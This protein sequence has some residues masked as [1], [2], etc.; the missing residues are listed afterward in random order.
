[1]TAQDEE[2]ELKKELEGV[3]KKIKEAQAA[4]ADTSFAEVCKDLKREA[5]F[6]MKQ[7]RVLKGHI[8]KVT[9][10]H[11]CGD[12]KKAV[13]GSLDGKLIVWD[14]FSGNK[15]RVIP[16]RSSWVMS[17]AYA[18]NGNYVAVGGMDNMCT[19]YD[20]H[21]PNAKVRRE[22]TGL[23]GYLSSVRFLSDANVI[24]G[25]GDTKVVLW[26][27]DR[28]AKLTTY[29]GHEGDVTSLSMHPE[30]SCF[31]TGSVDN[32]ARLWDVR[33]KSCRQVFRD[34]TGD[35][36]CVYFHSGGNVFITA[37]EDKTCQLFDIRSDQVLTQYQNQRESCAFTCCAMSLSGRMVLAGSD[38]NDVHVWDTLSTR[39]IGNLMGHESRV[40]ALT[41]SP[42]GAA[43][44][45]GSWDSTVRAWG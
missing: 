2:A 6:H 7:R 41:I 15:M 44:V 12:S 5:K 8:S 40:T 29:E 45:S 25:S 34:H 36:N 21:G 3:L 30:K 10:A 42:D 35:V 43:I 23:D 33:E 39:R 37:S 13:S 28:G 24:T 38:D 4:A 11:F 16:L 20:L 18:E 31:V 17:C 19:V 32:T 27:I 22:L 14:V 9:S 1:M 26:D